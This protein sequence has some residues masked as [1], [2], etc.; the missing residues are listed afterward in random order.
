MGVVH[1]TLNAAGLSVIGLIACISNIKSHASMAD[2][3]RKTAVCNCVVGD[4][5]K[6]PPPLERQSPLKLYSLQS[7]W[8][9]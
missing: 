7:R 1:L 9:E 8:P 4:S 2:S 5:T 6:P 3:C